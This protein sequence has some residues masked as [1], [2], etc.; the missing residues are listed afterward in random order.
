MKLNLIFLIMVILVAMSSCSNSKTDPENW[1]DEE[2]NSWFAKKEW[3]NGWNVSPDES[4]NKR[5]L[6]ISYYKNPARWDL[7]F[8]FLK[9]ANLNEQ[10]LGKKE[11][12]GENLFVSVAEYK[13]K[14][15]PE[16]RYESHKKYI[17]IQYI[18]KGE[19][20]MGITT[21]DKVKVVEPYSAEN[22]ITFYEFDGGDYRK[23]TPENFF[24]YF[25]TDVHRPSISTGD[26]ALARKIVVKIRIE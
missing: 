12:D 14:E 17:D 22:D 15:K 9:T 7:A 18:I 24:I 2:V 11:L 16:T 10:P 5:N 8:Q 23:A 25:P 3:L 4:V 26:T 21:L 20:L 19:E 1:S 13:A 6:A